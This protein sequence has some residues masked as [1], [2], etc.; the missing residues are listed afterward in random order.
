MKWS[1]FYLSHFPSHVEYIS[2]LLHDNTE[3]ILTKFTG[4]N[5]YHEQIKLLHF[6]QN[7]NRNK[8]TGYDTK[9]KSTS[10]GLVTVSKRC[11]GVANEFTAQTTVDVR[12]DIIS[13]LFR[14]QWQI[15]YKYIKNF[16]VIFFIC[17]TIIQYLSTANTDTFI[18]PFI[19]C[20]F[21]A[22]LIHKTFTTI[23]GQMQQRRHHMTAC[24]L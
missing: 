17:R 2:F 12:A 24:G 16:T 5:H 6:G 18:C 11:W 10:V 21:L 23:V 8:G 3:Q 22:I 14:F 19:Y 4:G 7:W 20:I 9:F 15:V 13:H 1:V